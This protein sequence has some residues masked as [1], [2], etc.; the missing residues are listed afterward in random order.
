MMHHARVPDPPRGPPPSSGP[1]ATWAHSGNTETML[2]VMPHSKSPTAHYFPQTSKHASRKFSFSIFSQ[3]NF[4][5]IFHHV[6][7][8]STTFFQSKRFSLPQN[9]RLYFLPL[10]THIPVL[11]TC[12]SLSTPQGLGQSPIFHES[13]LFPPSKCK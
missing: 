13:F 3:F 10:L 9:I 1:C 4:S 8:L 5:F 7:A 12:L 2:T 6:S 11:K